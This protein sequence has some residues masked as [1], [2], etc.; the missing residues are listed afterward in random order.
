MSEPPGVVCRECPDRVFANV[1]GDSGDLRLRRAVAQVAGLDLP[2]EPG[3]WNRADRS[4]AYW[5]GPDEWLLVVEG[6]D[7]LALEERLRD[8]LDGPFSVADVTGAQVQ[9]ELS[10]PDAGKVLQK[11]SPYDFHPRKFPP[12]RCAQTVFSKT[13]ALVAARED[14]A[15]DVVFR[16]SYADY[17]M[18][19]LADAA[20]EYGYRLE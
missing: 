2:R 16:R 13:T 17:L 12:G 20:A 1:R 18:R 4:R 5:L 15:F 11:S 8:A 6:D 9:L 10:G 14:G 19:W 7:G 3:T